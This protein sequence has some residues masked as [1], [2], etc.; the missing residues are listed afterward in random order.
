MR[1]ILNK[2]PSKKI[3]IIGDI[4]LDEYVYGTATRISPEAPVPILKFDYNCFEIG[5]AGNVASN[6]ASM[7]ADAVL[8]S[9]VGRDKEAEILKD[10]LIQRRI[11]CFL[12]KNDITTFK[13]RLVAKSH[14]MLR[15]D[16]EETSEKIFDAEI[17][18]MLLKK[19]AEADIIII[20]DYA[21][22][23]ITSDL[24]ELLEPYKSKMII[25]PKPA[26][27]ALKK[28]P[29]LYKNALLITPN[30]KESFQ[31]S[32]LNDVYE[33]GEKLRKELNTNVM[34]T[35]AEKG[36]TLFSDKIIELPTFANE[37]HDLTGA[38]DS[39]I[40]ALALS[41]SAGASLE[42]AA[43]ISNNA[44]A[45]SVERQ[46]TYSV[47]LNEIEKRIF[48]EENKVLSLEE[49]KK[50]LDGEKAKGK[51]IVW[52]NGC[53][54]IYSRG[55]KA[56]L[57]GAAKEGHILI[58]GLDSDESIRKLKGPGRPINSEIERAEILSSI[59]YVDY[60]TI[61]PPDGVKECLKILKPDVYIKGGDYTI[62]S[63][64]Q[65]ERKIVESYGGSI[66]LI[67]KD[68]KHHTKDMIKEISG[69]SQ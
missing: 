66:K 51:R 54:D 26:N 1:E 39:M 36:M 15:I 38:G 9:F 2:F 14:H 32:G 65:E 68:F 10:L 48:R 49:L 11:F 28:N 5:G 44:A 45:I 64:N 35:R 63:I 37:V 31:L 40:A 22:G 16:K 46:G 4:M 25:D 42:T 8:F 20:S 34:I 29:L 57:E 58:V 18:T 50:I 3:L 6:I 56:L 69:N 60:I 33:A 53:F 30:E 24:M 7:N 52:T 55:Q 12:D 23:V 59:E 67:G 41:L 17:K 47:T 27:P 19:S 62:E 13:Q 61:F 21:K 43:V